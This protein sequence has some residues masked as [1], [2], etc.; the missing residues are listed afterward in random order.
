MKFHPAT[1]KV[2]RR[3]FVTSLGARKVPPGEILYE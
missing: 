1:V 2:A 3:D